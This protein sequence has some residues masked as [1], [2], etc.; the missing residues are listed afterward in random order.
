ME[1][2]QV[3][4]YIKNN[5]GKQSPREIAE[6]LGYTS[7]Y[8]RQ[9]ARRMGYRRQAPRKGNRA[10]CKGCMLSTRE[11]VCIYHLE[12][13]TWRCRSMRYNT[14]KWPEKETIWTI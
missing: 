2:A 13:E 6:A 5:Y 11:G 14:T 12:N 4:T 8:I 9:V 1:L 7:D 10:R 3:K